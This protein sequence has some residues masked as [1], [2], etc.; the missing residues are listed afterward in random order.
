MG[1]T[2][3]KGIIGNDRWKFRERKF[4][5]IRRSFILLNYKYLIRQRGEK[6]KKKLSKKTPK[7]EIFRP[8]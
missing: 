1:A 6:K 2:H 4:A 3:Q 5:E 7:G 8:W